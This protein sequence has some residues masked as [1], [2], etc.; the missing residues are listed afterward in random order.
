MFGTSDTN[1]F[2]TDLVVKSKNS[3]LRDKM[4]VFQFFLLSFHLFTWVWLNELGESAAINLHAD[5]GHLAEESRREM[6]CN[7]ISENEKYCKTTL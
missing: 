7:E 2:H 4:S 5:I 6:W 3:R 1:S